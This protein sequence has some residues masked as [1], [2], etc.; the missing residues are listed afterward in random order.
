MVRQFNPERVRCCGRNRAPRML[1][2]SCHKPL[3][4]LI[5]DC[6]VFC[7]TRIGGTAVVERLESHFKTRVYNATFSL[8][9]FFIC[10]FICTAVKARSFFSS[11]SGCNGVKIILVSRLQY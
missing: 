5:F 6:V 1:L 9:L 7:Q 4:E 8:C 2:E 10:V 3:S 11:S